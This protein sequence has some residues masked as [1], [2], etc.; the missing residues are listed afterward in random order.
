MVTKILKLIILL[1]LLSVFVPLSLIA[2]SL[3]CL[4]TNKTLYNKYKQIEE[5]APNDIK[6]EIKILRQLSPERIDAAIRIREA[7]IN[8]KYAVLALFEMLV[9]IREAASASAILDYKNGKIKELHTSIPANE[10]AKLSF[11]LVVL[12]SNF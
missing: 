5:R 2:Q 9:D 8:N 10:A 12:Q 6:Y 7:G 1:I 3:S 4:K 11:K